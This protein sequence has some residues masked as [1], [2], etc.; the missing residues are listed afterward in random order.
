MYKNNKKVFK[1]VD[2]YG[3]KCP[4]FVGYFLNKYYLF[5]SD[6]Y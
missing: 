3:L 5:V 1:K 2:Y 4:V 6:K